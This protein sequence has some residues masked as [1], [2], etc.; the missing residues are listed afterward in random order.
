MHEKKLKKGIYIKC[1]IL[2]YEERLKKPTSSSLVNDKNWKRLRKVRNNVSILFKKKK[3]HVHFSLNR[4]GLKKPRLIG[5]KNEGKRERNK[6][7]KF[8]HDQ[9]THDVRSRAPNSRE[10]NYFL[11]PCTFLFLKCSILKF[12]FSIYRI[13]FLYIATARLMN[14]WKSDFSDKIT[15]KFFQAV[16]MLVLLCGY[17][18]WTL[19]KRLEKLNGNHKRMLC[20]I[21]NNSWK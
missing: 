10:E 20:A 13:I 21:L 7:S 14:I 19:T 11:S 17:T 16:V 18:T 12:Y 8:L 3:N 6:G 15:R 9:R 4:R 2:L 1:F 5:L